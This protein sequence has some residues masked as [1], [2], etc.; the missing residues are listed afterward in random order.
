[1]VSRKHLDR[2]VK[3]CGEDRPRSHWQIIAGK[4]E[5]ILSADKTMGIKRVFN[6]KE[7]VFFGQL[8]LL[9]RPHER[10]IKVGTM[11]LSTKRLLLAM[12]VLHRRVYFNLGVVI[13]GTG[14]VF[15]L[16]EGKD[17]I[18]IAPAFP[19]PDEA[20]ESISIFEIIHPSTELLMEWVI[21]SEL[22]DLRKS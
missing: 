22:F 11:Y 2:F 8:K 9:K 12:R 19:L 18:L 1:M 14:H 6:S 15:F 20:I 4:G 17:N 7:V 3:I 16:K 5:L 13:F 21:Y 10:F